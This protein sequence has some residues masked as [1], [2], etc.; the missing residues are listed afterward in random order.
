MQFCPHALIICVTDHFLSWR[1]LR[2]GRNMGKKDIA[3]IRYFEDEARYAD[4][5]NGFVFGGKP[6]VRSE[7]VLEKNA[8]VH[9]VFRRVREYFSVQKY[10]DLVRKVVLGMDF[11]LVG[12]ENQDKVHY[13]MPIRVMVEDAAGYDEQM[14]RIRREHRR[15]GGL[16]GAEFL[17]GFSREDRIRPVFTIVLYYGRE[18]WDGARDLHSLMAYEGLPEELKPLVNNY[19]IHVLELQRFGDLSRFRTDLRQVFG[20][21]QRAGDKDAEQVYTDENRTVFEA[22]DED[23]YDVISVLTGSEE[24]AAIKETYQTEEGKVNMCEAIRGMIEDGRKDGRKEGIL[25][26]SR[27][28]AKNL[29]QRGMSAEEVAAICEQDLSVVNQ[30][31]DLWKKEA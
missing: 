11:V 20:F 25:E 15:A 3:L 31:F 26:A 6:V 1:G 10:R 7:D 12:I 8:A 14:R 27:T 2:K 4:L 28:A 23:A 13:A 18:P 30:W 17:S 22:L 19:R 21:I 29:Y 16:E 5:I 24:L 9:G